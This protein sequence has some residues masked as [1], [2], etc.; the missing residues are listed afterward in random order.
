M[1]IGGGAGFVNRKTPPGNRGDK[2]GGGG[3]G[4]RGENWA[5]PPPKNPA[6]LRYESWELSRK[7]A[8]EP[9]P[10][11][12]G[13]GEMWDVGKM[14]PAPH[15]P[16]NLR[17]VPAEA[18]KNEPAGGA[19][20]ARLHF[21]EKC[22]GHA[23]HCV[24]IPP[25]RKYYCRWVGLLFSGVFCVR[26]MDHQL[27]ISTHCLSE[28]T[29]F[30]IFPGRLLG[31]FARYAGPGGPRPMFPK[32]GPRTNSRLNGGRASDRRGGPP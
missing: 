9:W 21:P 8:V 15:Y 22:R 4:G 28:K 17:P 31:N 3:G 20:P 12:R 14:G 30:A 13:A 26:K 2:G 32:V 6:R 24:G 29:A 23:P 1:S 16:W 19:A 10:K 25:T 7:T 11:S 5:G 18:G 27:T